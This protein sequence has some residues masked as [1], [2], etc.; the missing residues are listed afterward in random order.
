MGKLP[1][2]EGWKREINI[3]EK[4]VNCNHSFILWGADKKTGLCVTCG[5]TVKKGDF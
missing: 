4:R 1:I 5:S 2:M 3:L